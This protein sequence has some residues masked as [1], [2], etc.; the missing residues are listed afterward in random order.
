M[1]V[2]TDIFAARDGMVFDVESGNFRGGLDADVGTANLVRILHD[3]GTYDVRRGGI[4]RWHADSFPLI[5]RVCMFGEVSGVD[6]GQYEVNVEGAGPGEFSDPEAGYLIP[7]TANVLRFAVP[8]EAKIAGP[9]LIQQRVTVE[10]A[11]PG[12]EKQELTT[13]CCEMVVLSKTPTAKA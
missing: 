13:A 12:H 11:N 6:P 4:D 10:L 9:G 3:D 8:L 1:P 7:E 2:G 5:I